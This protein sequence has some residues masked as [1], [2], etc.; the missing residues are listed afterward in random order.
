MKN[1]AIVLAISGLI[2]TGSA[3]AA[4]HDVTFNPSAR[5]LQAVPTGHVVG[6]DNS[7][8]PEDKEFGTHMAGEDCGLCHTPGGKADPN[9]ENKYV[10]TMAGTLYEDKAA[11]KP[12]AGGEVILTDYSGKVISMT[13]NEAGNFWTYEPIASY[14]LAVAGHGNVVK[15]YTETTVDNGDGTTTT[16]V[17]PAP[18]TDSRSWLYKVWVKKGDQVIQSPDFKPVG[19]GSGT[20]PRMGCGMHHAPSGS[21]GALWLSEK[22][23]LAAYPETGLSFKK[24]ILPI[25]MS[26]CASCHRPGAT[27]TRAV[28]KSDIEP[29]FD[30]ANP[31][32]LEDTDTE[33]TMYDFSGMHDLTAYEDQGTA[34]W[35]KHGTGYYS[36]KDTDNPGMNALLIKTVKGGQDHAGGTF[37]AP[38][39]PD[40][41]AI[42]QWIAEGGLNN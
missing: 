11:R 41:K 32:N 42:R 5:A 31:Y 12:L 2:G 40:Y 29:P 3:I 23:T 15:L 6:K 14:P 22:G 26:K 4:L 28:M 9:N 18:E 36:K 25:L 1:K 10:F 16:T 19:G 33:S 27:T 7:P 38:D 39:H 13:S 30:L 8:D 37:W 17:T 20:T 24:H 21:R 34:P 35:A